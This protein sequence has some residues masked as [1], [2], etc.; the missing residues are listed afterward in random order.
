MAQ[1]AFL[2]RRS[3]LVRASQVLL[4]CEEATEIDAFVRRDHLHSDQMRRRNF[5][6]GRSEQENAAPNLAY[7]RHLHRIQRLVNTQKAK[8]T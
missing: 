5:Q 4:G 1:L 2:L 6:K 8:D 7:H 3:L